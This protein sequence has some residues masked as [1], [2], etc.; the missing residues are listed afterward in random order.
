MLMFCLN[1]SGEMTTLSE[2]LKLVYRILKI[3]HFSPLNETDSLKLSQLAVGTMNVA[4]A[5]I[6]HL[7]HGSSGQGNAGGSSSNV[8]SQTQHGSDSMNSLNESHDSDYQTG[9]LIVAQ[10]IW[11]QQRVIRILQDDIG[12]LQTVRT[13]I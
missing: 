1:G 6:N 12:L 8:S 10:A 2:D 4:F 13:I 5:I 7:Y 9:L 3:C 11:V